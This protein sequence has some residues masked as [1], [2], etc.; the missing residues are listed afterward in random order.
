VLAIEPQL[1]QDAL[2][3]V[4]SE[5]AQLA[6]IA[7][8]PV[9]MVDDWRVR[10]FVKKLVELEF[11]HLAVLSKREAVSPDSRLVLATIEVESSHQTLGR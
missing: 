2:T 11:P 5:V 3:A 1:T 8:N 7:K 10:S 6:P 4:R 9:L